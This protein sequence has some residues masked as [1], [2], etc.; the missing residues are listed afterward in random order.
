MNKLWSSYVSTEDISILQIRRKIFL[1]VTAS[2]HGYDLTD[3]QSSY[4]CLPQYLYFENYWIGQFLSKFFPCEVQ[5]IYI[6]ISYRLLLKNVNL[7]NPLTVLAK[8]RIWNLL[9]NRWIN[10]TEKPDLDIEVSIVYLNQIFGEIFGNGSF[11][12]CKTMIHKKYLV[13]R[14]N[15]IWSNN[16][17]LANDNESWISGGRGFSDIFASNTE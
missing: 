7:P 3:F 1:L 4:P 2:A 6:Y 14:A 8:V 5:L 9:E 13:V 16:L 11:W 10:Y 15:F 12:N 17:L